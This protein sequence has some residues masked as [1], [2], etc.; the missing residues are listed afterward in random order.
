MVLMA[1]V[2][3]MIG[4]KELRLDNPPLHGFRDGLGA[5]VYP[6][7]IENMAYLP[8]DSR[9]ADKQAAAYLAAVHTIRNQFQQP[10]LS[11]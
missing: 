3:V 6:E 7:L 4:M 1:V 5:V 10:Q 8:F 2:V 9:G 11:V